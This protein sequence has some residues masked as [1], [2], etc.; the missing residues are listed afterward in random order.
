MISVAPGLGHNIDINIYIYHTIIYFK[1]G[2]A[3][4]SENEVCGTKVT[5][6]GDKM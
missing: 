2:G 1:S 4:F 3:I 5:K 6:M